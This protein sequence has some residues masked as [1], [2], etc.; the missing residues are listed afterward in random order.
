MIHPTAIVHPNARID[1]GVEIG[2][3]CIVGEHVSV[4]T[5]TVL[6]AHVVINGL[7]EIG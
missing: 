5:G 1:R 3:Y 2:P 6:Q 4:G 7:T